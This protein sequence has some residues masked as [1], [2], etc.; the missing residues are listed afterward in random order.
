MTPFLFCRTCM[1]ILVPVH[2]NATPFCHKRDRQECSSRFCSNSREHETVSE[3]SRLCSSV[4]LSWLSSVTMS[5]EERLCL[6][7]G[8]PEGTFLGFPITT[9]LF[10]AAHRVR[11][12]PLLHHCPYTKTPMISKIMFM[13]TGKLNQ[14]ASRYRTTPT[15]PMNR[16]VPQ[17]RL[18]QFMQITE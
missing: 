14:Q 12:R 17:L 11:P 5:V 16:S 13:R 3:W 18:N 4:H 10:I 2:I 15:V 1:V 7:A 6:L 9:C 8:T